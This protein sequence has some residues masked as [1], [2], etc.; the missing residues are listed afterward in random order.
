ML[1]VG[2]RPFA[3]TALVGVLVTLAACG[4]DDDAATGTT[5]PIGATTGGTD[6]AVTTTTVAPTTPAATSAAP[7]ITDATGT[8][9]VTA[10]ATPAAS[11]APAG[12]WSDPAGVY[13][14][15]FPVDPSVQQLQAPLPDGTTI[16]VT[17]YLA[18]L[19]GATAITSCTGFPADSAIDPVPVLDAARDGA[20]ANFGGELV[21]SAPIELQGRPGVSYRG[22]IGEAG[23]MLGRSFINGTELCQALVVGEPPVVDEIGPTFLDSF[24]FL[25]ENA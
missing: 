19:G 1:S 21:E 22:A 15:M 2:P 17:A 5:E 6:D 25:Q 11:T 23:A 14:A 4:G 7:V 12:P 18:E 3:T 16:P 9:P 20:L 10:P 24:Q 13:Q 8:A